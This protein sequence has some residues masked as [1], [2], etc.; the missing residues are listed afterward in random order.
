MIRRGETFA[1]RVCLVGAAVDGIMLVP[2]L[3]PSIGGKLFGIANFNPGPDYRY[4]MDVGASLML[5]WTLLLLWA[6]DR[7]VERAGVILLTVIVVLGLGAAGAGAV[8]SGFLALPAMAP[9]FVLQ[10]VLTL[11]FSAA[12]LKVRR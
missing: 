2:M 6:S 8:L 1:R 9:T 4:A 12:F 5:G 3:A 10:A 11:L 7:P